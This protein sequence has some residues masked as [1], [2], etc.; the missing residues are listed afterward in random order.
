MDSGD[1][2]ILVGVADRACTLAGMKEGLIFFWTTPAYPADFLFLFFSLR[3]LQL[4]F[5][6]PFPFPCVYRWFRGLELAV[7]VDVVVAE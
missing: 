6:R 7:P 2:P 4:L 5:L 3:L 1:L